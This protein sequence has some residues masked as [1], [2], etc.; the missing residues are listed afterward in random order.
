MAVSLLKSIFSSGEIAP[1]LYGQADNPKI[2]AGCS[3][4]RNMFVTY[5]GGVT[6]RAGLAFV[7]MMK[8][9]ASASSTPPR[10]IAFKYSIT[11]SYILEFGDQYLRIVA[12]GG[13]ITDPSINIT[14]VTNSYPCVVSAVNSYANGDWVYL[15]GLGGITPLDGETYIVDAATATSFQ[16]RD[17]FGVQVDSRQFPAYTSGGIAARITTFVSPYAAVDLPYLKVV[18]S[19]DVMTLCCVN[20]QTGV[21]Y[22]SYDLS[23]LAA[24]NWSFAQAS[25]AATI[26]PPATCTA[27]ASNTSPPSGQTLANYQ[28]VVTAVDPVTGDESVSSPVASVSSVDIGLT[29]GSI[30]ITWASVSG[31]S[32]YNIYQAPVAC[33]T[34]VN[35]PIGANFGYIG[36]AFGTQFI[37]SNITPDF[38]SSPPG[39]QNPFAPS[40]VIGAT[41]TAGGTSYTQATV[42]ATINTMTGSGAV[43]TPVV[44]SGAVVAFIIQNSGQNYLPTDTITISDS[45]SGS[46]ALATLQVGPATG[47]N[48]SVASYFQSRRTYASTI[49]NP[50]TLFLSHPNAYLNFDQSTPPQDHD[51]ITTTPWGVQVNGIQWLVPLPYGLLVATG[52]DI[53]MV[54]GAGG[55]GAAITPSSQQALAQESNGFSPTVRPLKVGP[56]ILYVG[57]LNTQVWDAKYQYWSQI[58]AAIDISVTSNHLFENYTVNQWDYSKHPYKV[59]WAPRNDGKFLCLTWL[60]TDEDQQVSGSNVLSAWSRHDTNGIVVDVAVATEPP[61]DAP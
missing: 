10:I 12:N 33:G 11:Q 30:T 7:G 27:S 51:G 34:G 53:W 50:D 14:G 3:V 2:Q 49:N 1:S 28:F 60:K 26:G 57:S 22:P 6:S 35:V 16:I 37:N 40:T 52:N 58:Y 18:Q 39:H 54:S 17:T 59:A 56:D 48:P 43:I 13:Y 29:E 5:K 47:V 42:S 4:L 61:V 15:T 21:E 55:A 31:A 38:T 32:K 23:R 20:Q 46:G 24:N 45:G 44:V 36:T 41:V 19:A 9:P 25:F 8:Q